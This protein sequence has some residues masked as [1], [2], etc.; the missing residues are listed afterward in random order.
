MP[1][2]IQ[3]YDSTGIEF[4]EG[5][6][7]L[8]RKMEFAVYKWVGDI[9]KLFHFQLCTRNGL[10][11]NDR[12]RNSG[13]PLLHKSNNNVG[14]NCQNLK[15]LKNLTCL[16][17]KFY[18]TLE[19]SWSNPRSFYSRKMAEFLKEQSFVTIFIPLSSALWQP[20]ILQLEVMIAQS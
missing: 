5:R 19:S 4:T 15:F 16:K 17:F 6:F 18:R 8:L 2:N 7:A 12:V 14:K 13:N 9:S 1:L 20:G 11:R 3:L 10:Q